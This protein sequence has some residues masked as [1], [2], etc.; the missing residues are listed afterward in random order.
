MDNNNICPFDGN[1]DELPE[2]LKKEIARSNNFVLFSSIN[3]QPLDL[4][5]IR[6]FE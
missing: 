1:N 4:N 5:D 6:E 3:D 2:E